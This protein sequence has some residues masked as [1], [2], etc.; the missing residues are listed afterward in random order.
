MTRRNPRNTKKNL[1]S[2]TFPNRIR[3]Q[4]IYDNKE[5][6]HSTIEYFSNLF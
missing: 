2:F 1:C 3:K 5:K 4:K 6:M